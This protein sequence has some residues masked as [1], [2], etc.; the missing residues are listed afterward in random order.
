MTTAVKH[1]SCQVVL[2]ATVALATPWA[3]ATSLV[4]ESSTLRLELDEHPYSYCVTEKSTGKVLVCESSTAFTVRSESYPVL[5]LANVIQNSNKIQADMRIERAGRDALDRATRDH[6]MVSFAFVRPGVLQIQITYDPATEI[7]EEFKD[8]GEHYYGIWEYPFGGNIENRGADHDFIGLGAERH[9]HHASARA[10]FYMTSRGY[11]IYVESLALGHFSIAQAGR[12]SFSFKDSHLTYDVIYGPSYSEVMNRYN[13]MAGPAIMPPL[14]AFGTIWWRD[15]EHEDLRDVANAQD[16]VIQDADRLRALKIPAAA[17]WLDRPYG[18]GDKGWGNMDFDSSFPDPPKM[19]RDLNDRGMK[20][21]LWSANRA[22]SGLFREGS[23]KDY[24]YSASWPAAEVQRPEVYAWFKEKLSAYVRLGVRGYKIDRGEEGEMPTAAENELSVLFPK[25]SSEGLRDVYGDDYF[26]FSRNVDDTARRYTAL[27]NGD[28]WSNF[29]GLQVSI[30]TGLRAGLIDFP[31]WGSDTG[32]YFAPAVKDKE[33]LARWLEFSAFS[34]MMEVILGPGR[35]IWY[36]YDEEL[37]KIAQDYAS[38]HHDFVP[39]TRSLMY[40]AAR[41]GLPI[42]RPL[43]LAYP[44]EENLSDMW[45]EYLYGDGLL[46]AP[47]TTAKTTERSV[48]LPPGRWMDYTDK[49]TVQEGKTALTTSAPLG[50]VPVFV[51]E[52][53]V[54]PRGDIVKLNNNWDA[55]WSPKL[56]IEIFPARN[57]ETIFQYFTGK[58]EEAIKSIP[59]PSGLTVQFGDL[60]VKGTV[61][62]YCQGASGITRNGVILE[63]DRDY[64]YDAQTHL[65]TVAFEGATT[66][67]IAGAR[68]IF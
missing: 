66:L 36:D 54:V 40:Q 21:L 61:E 14:W 51:R 57:Q 44:S 35:T 38:L 49:R 67:V 29:D 7:S 5:G 60:G 28:S 32:G 11:G 16:K 19:I 9:V 52:G 46:V 43:F 47:V 64:R 27:W 42:M 23:Q 59:A 37:V 63:K 34:P 50:T 20:L 30:K 24:L 45:D 17:I 25:L 62:V 53:A 1:G 41:T 2:L 65:L 56:R 55:N 22:S 6:A 48:Y 4:L 26:V 3:L 58:S 10:P 33:L 18:S 12:T 68:S 8:Q 31:M 39:Y 15:D 13:A